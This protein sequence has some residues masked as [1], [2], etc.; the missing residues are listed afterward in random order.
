MGNNTII[1][2]GSKG[3]STNIVFNYLHKKYPDIIAI[4]EEKELLEV[5]LKRRIRKLGF[6]T[7]IGQVAFQII[8]AKP[9]SFLS[10]KREREIILLN[11][12]DTTAIPE[13]KIKHVSSVNSP[14]TIEF[15][16]SNHPDLVV[17]NGT[18]IIS[19]NVLSCASCRFI[20]I[21][22]G[23]TP[24]YRGVHGM[25]WAL[26]NNDKENCGVTVHFVDPGIDTG[27]VIYQSKVV[28]ASKDNFA[29][30]PLLQLSAGLPLLGQA[31]D[32]YFNN[33]IIVK[34]GTEESILWYHPTLWQYIYN[35]IFRKAP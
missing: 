16:K 8:I 31:I 22:A 12:L 32:D 5:F 30:Y 24:K 20:N 3:Q 2:L 6:A 17:V 13:N 9:L 14:H 10:R 35:R 19:K 1:L 33:Q 23:I 34:R 21:H 11:K 27:N 4:L 26:A 25:Y 7:V 18:R 29:T 28:P 15:I